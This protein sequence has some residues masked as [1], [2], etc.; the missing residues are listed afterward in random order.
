MKTWD[1]LKSWVVAIGFCVRTRIVFD[2]NR[3]TMLVRK[4]KE[5]FFCDS[6]ITCQY[7]VISTR[8]SKGIRSYFVKE[9][10]QKEESSAKKMRFHSVKN[11]RNDR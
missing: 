2:G 9:K 5:D 7:N 11:Q 10:W 8:V 3:K 1:W 6:D 4:K